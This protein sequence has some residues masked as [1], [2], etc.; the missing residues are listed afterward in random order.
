MFQ[1]GGKFK[2]DSS[3]IYD[4]S[5][6]SVGSGKFS[7]NTRS[8]YYVVGA[9]RAGKARTGEVYLVK[10]FDLTSDSND[11]DVEIVQTLAGKQ[12]GEYFGS[13]FVSADL[14]ADGL[15]ELI[16]GSPLTTHENIRNKRSP[17]RYIKVRCE[18]LHLKVII[19][20]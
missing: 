10:Q 11:E 2:H 8:R 20:C 15:D 9:P 13:S 12:L 17:N 14:D 19:R 4:Y 16:V 18:V 3:S 6:Y 1:L 5:G 7:R